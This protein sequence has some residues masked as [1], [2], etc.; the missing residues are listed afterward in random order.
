MRVICITAFL[1]SVNVYS[2]PSGNLKSGGDSLSPLERTVDSLG[3][4][5]YVDADS[6][7]V[8][9]IKEWIGVNY[10][11]G[12]KSKS[13][14]DCSGFANLLYEQVYGIKLLRVS[15]EIYRSSSKV[16]RKDLAQGD[17]VFFKTNGKSRVNHV[18]VYLWDGYFV[19]SSTKYGVIIST[20]NEGY[21]QKTFVSGGRVS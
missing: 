5:Q 4:P 7:L 12:G 6:Q 17:L 1:L 9:F 8:W 21:Y 13:G 11:Y 19:H 18:G 16:K 2:Y 20:L 10:C 14:V 15:T 3:L